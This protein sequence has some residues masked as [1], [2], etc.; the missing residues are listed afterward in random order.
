MVF[1][2]TKDRCMH[3]FPEIRNHAGQSLICT[4]VR[5]TWIRRASPFHGASLVLMQLSYENN[6]NSLGHL[7]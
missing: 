5:S 4:D 3:L 2:A 6:T 7:A 1:V